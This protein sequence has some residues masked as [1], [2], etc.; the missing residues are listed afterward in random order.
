MTA[1]R[2]TRRT[3]QTFSPQP[4]PQT[5]F[6]A[7]AADVAIFGGAAGSGKSFA[8]LYEASKWAHI[9]GYRGVLFRRTSPELVGGGGLWD[10]ARELYSALGGKSRSFPQLDWTFPSG[11]RI[12]FRHLQ[13]EQDVH[14]HHGRQYAFVGFDELTT[15]TERQFWYLVSRLRSSCGVRPYIRATCNPDPESFVA[16]LVQWWIG[17]DGYPIP[18]RSGVLRWLIRDGDELRWYATEDEARAAHPGM[19][20]LSFT[21]I[22]ATL[23][24]NRK[25]LDKDPTYRARLQALSR[26]DRMRLLGDEAKGGNWLVR[27]SAGLVFRRE[28]FRI[29]R[30]APSRILRTV[31]AWDKGAQAPSVRRPDPDWTRGVR[32]S[33]CASGELWIDDL[34]SLRDRP[35]VVLDHMRATAEEDGPSVVIGLWQD[36]GQAGVVDVDT[37]RSALAGFPVEVVSAIKDK[38]AWAKVWAPHVERGLVHVVPET[39]ADILVAECDGFPDASHDDTVDAVSLAAQL[40]FGGG[41][42]FW[43][44]LDQAADQLANGWKR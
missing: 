40:L 43:D 4:G 24:D 37:T 16:K 6:A 39:W 41:T 25:L 23:R 42:G 11:A 9:G 34:V 8:L 17:P 2:E 22:G 19:A 38:Y 15:F 28:D 3:V 32:V 27:P 30:T 44:L 20:P 12:E 33:S 14:A 26:V 31:R 7:C 13:R 29:A 5:A 36:P 18:E 1:Q 35:A 10:E 21:F